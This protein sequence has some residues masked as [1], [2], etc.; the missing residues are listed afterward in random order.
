M[1]EMLRQITAE[2]VGFDLGQEAAVTARAIRENPAVIEVTAR[3]M[4]TY[5]AEYLEDRLVSYYPYYRNLHSGEKRLF[6][7]DSNKE[8][9]LVILGINPQERGGAVVEGFTNLERAIGSIETGWFLWISPRGKAG[10]EG[11]YQHITYQEHQVYVGSIGR[12]KVDVYA[13]QSDVDEK[14]LSEWVHVAS[15]GSKNPDP[16]SADSFV[17]N[18]IFLPNLNGESEI[19]KSLLT[20]RT[21][22]TVSGENLFYKNISVDKV[23]ALMKIQGAKQEEE[24]RQLQN[25]LSYELSRPGIVNESN[26]GEILGNHMVT[27][28]RQFQDES[29]NVQLHGCVGGS[30]SINQLFDSGLV[31]TSND[32]FSTAFRVAS[33]GTVA[34]SESCNKISCKKC[35]WEA[36]DDEKL[37]EGKDYYFNDKGLLV[38]TREFLLKRGFCCHNNCTNCPCREELSKQKRRDIASTN[39]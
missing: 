9:D 12:N 37:E 33:S 22:L 35:S 32:V 36:S 1:R 31:Q 4:E 19:A 20:L 15:K 11:I 28:F 6:R 17:I 27:L 30:I 14:L 3:S 39:R 10:T 21:L 5:K 23:F 8:E 34:M 26:V 7:I 24:V 25:R 2:K 18:P 29:G 38:L 16:K 13:L